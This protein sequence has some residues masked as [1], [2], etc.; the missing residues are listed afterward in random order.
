MLRAVFRS[1]VAEVEDAIRGM[2]QDVS[3]LLEDIADALLQR[4]AVIVFFELGF[5]FLER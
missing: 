4:A 1:D 2:M 5:V 3:S